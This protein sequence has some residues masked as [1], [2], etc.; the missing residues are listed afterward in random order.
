VGEVQGAWGQL[1]ERIGPTVW[2]CAVREYPALVRKALP[3]QLLDAFKAVDHDI[4]ELQA[5]DGVRNFFRLALL[6]LIPSFSRAI[7]TGGWPKWVNNSK[8]ASSLPRIL[9]QRVGMMI[10][11]PFIPEAAHGK[12]CKATH[13][14]LQKTTTCTLL[15]SHHHHIPI[16]M[17][18]RESSE[19][20]SRLA[21]LIGEKQG[22]FGIRVFTLTRKLTLNVS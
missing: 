5:S 1:K 2:N 10:S 17:I 20:S 21:L 7:A 16:G 15:L 13:E 8:R 4:A 11:R 19:S 14:P 18:T 12:Q 22:S 3:G 6:S 9:G